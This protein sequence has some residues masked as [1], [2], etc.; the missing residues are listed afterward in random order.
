MKSEELAGL[1]EQVADIL[2]AEDAEV[3]E[4][5]YEYFYVE[6]AQRHTSIETILLKLK[7]NYNL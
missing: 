5:L 6:N 4:A 7:E 2:K 1:I 3:A